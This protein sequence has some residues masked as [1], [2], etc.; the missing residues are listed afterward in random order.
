M[1]KNKPFY[2]NVLLTFV[3]LGLHGYLANKFFLLQNAEASGQSF[4]NLGGMWNCDAVNT[5]PYAKFLG[6]PIALWGFVTHLIF[7][8][9]QIMVVLRQDSKNIWGDLTVYLS[10]FIA[11]VS[12]VMGF[13]SITHLGSL[14]LFC[15]GA[16]SLSILNI[17]FLKLAGFN[18]IE[19]FKK[20]KSTLLD[21]TTW[22]AA[23]AIPLLVFILSS[24]W[25]GT[26]NSSE[27]K[28]LVN[29]RVAAWIAA[30]VAQFDSNLGLRLGA[31]PSEAKMTIIEF[32]D[33]L[34]PHCK[35]AAPSIK[36]FVQSRKDVALVFKAY[37]LDGTC[38]LDP[39]FNGKGSGIPCRLTLAVFCAE[40]LEQTGWKLYDS[41]FEDQAEYQRLKSVDEVDQKLCK[42][43]IQ[44]CDQLKRRDRTDEFL[45][46]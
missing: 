13:I 34:C 15:L 4:C 31:S 27:A 14:C 1:I 40:K 38:N 33:F 22:L 36:A 32:A 5:S 37:P 43:G 30:P 12:V 17:L 19:S 23:V 44:N 21:K 20:I 24:S 46:E 29:D 41:I 35:H 25:G 45:R 2:I 10:S 28:G 3:A 16:Y 42:S 9:S 39:G 18:Y 6:Q 11:A 8:L 7:L 26:L